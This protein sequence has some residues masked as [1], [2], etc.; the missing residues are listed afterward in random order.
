MITDIFGLAGP[1]PV[2]RIRRRM[3]SWALAPRFHPCC[4]R[5]VPVGVPMP[6]MQRSFSVTTVI[7]L[8]PSVLSTAGCPVLPG[9]SSPRYTRRDKPFYLLY[10][11]L[12]GPY[13]FFHRS[14]TPVCSL[15][16]N[17]S[18]PSTSCSQ[19]CARGAR[20]ASRCGAPRVR[21][22]ELCP[23][24]AC[25][26]GRTASTFF[27]HRSLSGCSRCSGSRRP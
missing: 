26:T 23:G 4:S 12:F 16:K 11:Y 1:G 18:V 8:P 9:L 17:E 27:R 6:S 14:H 24:S 19:L 20:C 2:P 15:F 21:E 3:R 10:E 25:G 22:P 5:A 13:P 7:K